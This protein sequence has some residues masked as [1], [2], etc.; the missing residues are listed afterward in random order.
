MLHGS[1]VAA[2]NCLTTQKKQE[3][4]RKGAGGASSSVLL[5]METIKTCR[6]SGGTEESIVFWDTG[7]TL[8][9]IT[10]DHARNLGLKGRRCTRG[11]PWSDGNRQS[12]NWC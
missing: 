4:T 5:Q 6:S 10:Y 7:S 12:T 11:I 8:S 9:L 3:E 2:V 1:S